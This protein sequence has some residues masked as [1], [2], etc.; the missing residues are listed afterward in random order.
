MKR[1]VSA[2]C[3]LPRLLLSVPRL[4][5]AVI[6]Q[7]GASFRSTSSVDL[8]SIVGAIRAALGDFGIAYT[9]DPIPIVALRHVLLPPVPVS[10]VHRFQTVSAATRVDQCRV[11]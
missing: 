10:S 9:G 7:A 1:V 3:I 5:R 4:Q 11:F 8:E 2:C 6:L